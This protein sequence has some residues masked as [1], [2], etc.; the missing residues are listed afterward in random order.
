[1][2]S[3]GNGLGQVAIETTNKTASYLKL[4]ITK[5]LPGHIDGAKQSL[6]HVNCSERS[7]DTFAFIRIAWL[8]SSSSI[9]Q[10][11]AYHFDTLPFS[12]SR[13]QYP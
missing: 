12:L 10:G 7:T 13:L 2:F 9:D 4:T 6:A 11:E 5:E 3:D 8:S 1:M